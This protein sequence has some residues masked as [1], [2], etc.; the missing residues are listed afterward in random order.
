MKLTKSLPVASLAIAAVAL[1]GVAPHGRMTTAGAQPHMVPRPP[2]LLTAP[3]NQTTT[4]V[5][6]GVQPAARPQPPYVLG[7]VST[8][9]R[10]GGTKAAA[11]PNNVTVQPRVV[12]DPPH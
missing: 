3:H 9:P 7:P 12:R 2:V 1:L 10:D 8:R 5:P 6:P 11:A 4:P